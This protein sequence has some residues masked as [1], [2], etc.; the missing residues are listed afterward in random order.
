MYDKKQVFFDFLKIIR[1]DKSFLFEN[2]K[3]IKLVHKPSNNIGESLDFA[4]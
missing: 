1:A 3:L 4:D 2:F